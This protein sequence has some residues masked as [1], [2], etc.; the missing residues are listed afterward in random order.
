MFLYSII[1]REFRLIENKE[2]ILSDY[3]DIVKKIT[4]HSK[5][6]AEIETIEVESQ[7][8][9]TDLEQLISENAITSMDQDA[10][11]QKYNKLAEKHNNLQKRHQ[12]LT[13]DIDKKTAKRNLMRAFLKTLVRQKTSSRNLMK[14]YGRQ[15]LTMLW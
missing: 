9:Q 3:D 2:K 11:T 10:Y 8:L 4:D 6:E 14:R 7:L 5:E 15:P 12:I 1:L 13:S